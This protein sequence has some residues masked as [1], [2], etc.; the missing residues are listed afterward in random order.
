MKDPPEWFSTLR[1]Q[2]AHHPR[3]DDV[4]DAVIV[5]RGA[6]DQTDSDSA[7]G[8][9]PPKDDYLRQYWNRMQFVMS[10]TTEGPDSEQIE[11]TVN[12]DLDQIDGGTQ[13]YNP[14]YSAL[15]DFTP[16]TTRTKIHT[17]GRHDHLQHT[18]VEI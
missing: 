14:A 3:H 8:A 4:I 17:Q 18:V 15:D 12:P 11:H 7:L 2:Y 5:W 1:E 6:S 10:A 13:P 16:P 9:E